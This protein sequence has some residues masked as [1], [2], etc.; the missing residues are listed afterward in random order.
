MLVIASCAFDA[1]GLLELHS[2]K[3][4]LLSRKIIFNLAS[5][6]THFFYCHTCFQI[7]LYS[8]EQEEHSS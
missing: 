2:L 4:Y 1:K 3:T 7:K 6:F 8:Q 5:F